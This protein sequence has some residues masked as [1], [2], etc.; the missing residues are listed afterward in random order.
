VPGI[1]RTIDQLRLVPREGLLRGGQHLPG[2]QVYQVNGARR[3]SGGGVLVRVARG[4]PGLP[5][6][7]GVLLG[8]GASECH[9]EYWNQDALHMLCVK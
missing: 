4:L 8:L 6:F 9:R 5:R 2:V 3:Q 1:L 7:P